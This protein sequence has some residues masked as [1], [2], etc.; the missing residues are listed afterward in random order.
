MKDKNES[1]TNKILFE[2]I[3]KILLKNSKKFNISEISLPSLLSRMPRNG[4]MLA[5]DITSRMA[6]RIESK[7][8]NMHLL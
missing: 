6:V 1:V 2:F 3:V 5:T 8:S 4:I 7:I